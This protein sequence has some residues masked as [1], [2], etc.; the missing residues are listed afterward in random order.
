MASTGNKKVRVYETLKKRIIN[1]ELPPG[2]PINEANFASDLGVSKT[3]VREALRQLERDGLV[4]NVPSRGSTI[5]HITSHEIVDVFQIREIIES[6][7]ARRSALLGGSEALAKIRDSYA[8]S[9]A[10]PDSEEH[11]VHEWGTWEDMHTAIVSSLGNQLLINVYAGLIDRILRIRNY[12]GKRLTRRR[13]FDVIQEH[14]TIIEAI[15]DGKPDDAE[16]AM[17]QHLQNASV[18]LIGLSRAGADGETTPRPLV[19]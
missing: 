1:N 7:A 13:F 8:D 5:T 4:E 3:P 6:G 11:Y 9:L 18:F 16:R 12:Y 2:M 15:L 17:R 10:H 14:N 19:P